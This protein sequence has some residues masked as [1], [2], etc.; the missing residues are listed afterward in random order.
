MIDINKNI[1]LYYADFLSLREECHPVTDTCKYFFVFGAP[2]N[3]V[4]IAGNTPYYDEN[5]PYIAQAKQELDLIYDKFGHEGVKSFI[6]KIGCVGAAGSVDAIRLLKVIH[7][8]DSNKDTRKALN[9]YYKWKSEQKFY[10]IVTNED[11][12]KVV[13]PCTKYVAHAEH[14]TPVYPGPNEGPELHESL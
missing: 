12:E 5:S 11:G 6:D 3:S 8:Y 9:K 7:H 13:A 14:E 1:L 10:H 4:F 2:I